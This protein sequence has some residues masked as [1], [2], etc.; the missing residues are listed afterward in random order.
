MRKLLALAALLPVLAF[1]Q[2]KEIGSYTTAS[3]LGGSERILADQSS[4]TVNILP[5]QLATYITACNA[6]GCLQNI[7]TTTGDANGPNILLGYSGNS[8]NT[9]AHTQIVMGGY[10]A[11]VNAIGASFTGVNSGPSETW[12]PIDTSYANILG[13]Y[14][15]VNNGYASQEIGVQHGRIY[16]ASDHSYLLGGAVNY[17]QNGTT[18]GIVGGGNDYINSTGGFNIILGASASHQTG[19]GAS[20]SLLGGSTNVYSAGSYGGIAGGF[21]NTVSSSGIGNGILYSGNSTVNGAGNYGIVLGGNTNIVGNYYASIT[22]GF[23]NSSVGY[24]SAVTACDSCL[25]QYSNSLVIGV[26][27]KDFMYGGLTYGGRQQAASGD[28]EA[29]LF[30]VSQQTTNATLTSLVGSGTTLQGTLPINTGSVG[31]SQCIG[32]TNGGTTLVAFQG[33]YA[34]HRGASGNITVDYQNWTLVGTD[35]IGVGAPPALQSATSSNIVLQV[36]GKASTT[37]DWNCDMQIATV[38]G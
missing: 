26:S 30:S 4:V 2:T 7:Y 31:T 3:A 8:L 17:I 25:A 38:T 19:A 27:Q 34:F 23:N 28:R 37:I 35:G 1:G 10:V 6:T 32:K 24:E 29:G 13:G 5:S 11:N 33:Q 21:T 9:T 22:G 15:N 14:D 36:T 12:S 20:V 16:Q 18:S